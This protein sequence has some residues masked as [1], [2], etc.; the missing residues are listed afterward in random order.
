MSGPYPWY[1]DIQGDE[2]EQGDLFEDCPVYLPT[3]DALEHGIVDF[4]W[5]ERDF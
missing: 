4:D 3:D 2:I 5:E 1:T